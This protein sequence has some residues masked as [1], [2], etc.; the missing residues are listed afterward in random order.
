MSGTV[1]RVWYVA[2]GSN[3]GRARFQCSLSGGP[4]DGGRREYA[5]C[6]DPSDPERTTGVD[7]PALAGRLDPLTDSG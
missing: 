3:L 2:Y 6:R 7:V 1:Q 5:G 4:P